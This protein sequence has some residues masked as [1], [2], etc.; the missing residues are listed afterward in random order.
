MLTSSSKQSVYEQLITYPP[1]LFRSGWF[2]LVDIPE[3]QLNMRHT[4]VILSRIDPSG[5]PP[6]ARDSPQIQVTPIDLR[7]KLG[8]ADAQAL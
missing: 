3:A 6:A 2:L 8:Y 4:P 7:N 5:S 1:L